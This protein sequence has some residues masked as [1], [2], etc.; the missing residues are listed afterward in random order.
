MR[1]GIYL[2]IISF[3]KSLKNNKNGVYFEQKLYNDWHKGQ[4][5]A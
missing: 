4:N 3:Y 2:R 1:N 5:M